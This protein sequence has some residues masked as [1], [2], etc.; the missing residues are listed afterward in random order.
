MIANPKLLAK[1]LGRT[2]L[3]LFKQVIWKSVEPHAPCVP[4]SL[5]ENGAE[6]VTLPH[7]V[8][9]P[10]QP[11]PGR[12]WAAASIRGNH[13]TETKADTQQQFRGIMREWDLE[14]LR[15]RRKGVVGSVLMAYERLECR[16]CIYMGTASELS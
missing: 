3:L 1:K 12:S 7:L 16:G 13:Q 5:S 8:A 10:E 9:E 15:R 2:G 11:S 14:R 4:V 6:M